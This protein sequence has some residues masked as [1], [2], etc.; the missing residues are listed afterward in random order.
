[1]Q[2]PQSC[3]WVFLPLPPGGLVSK[4]NGAF[5]VSFGVS[6]IENFQEIETAN[7]RNIHS[8]AYLIGPALE[9]QSKVAYVAVDESV[10]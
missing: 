10:K 9:T 1:M 8:S 5:E 6:A 2:S 4:A 7:E 3:N